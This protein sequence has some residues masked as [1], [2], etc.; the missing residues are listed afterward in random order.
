MHGATDGTEAV[1]AS[2]PRP[3]LETIV[4][5][6]LP[7]EEAFEIRETSATPGFITFTVVA[8]SKRA[9]GILVG[10]GGETVNALRRIFSVLSFG[11]GRRITI[12]VERNMS[13]AYEQPVR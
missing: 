4:R 5:G 2:D 7:P 12:E 3:L 8:D 9:R 1:S 10:T 13:N 11:F 6:M